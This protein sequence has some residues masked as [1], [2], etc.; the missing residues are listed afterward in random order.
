MS[1]R[2]VEKAGMLHIR[3]RLSNKKGVGVSMV[4]VRLVDFICNEYVV[5]YAKYTE[6]MNLFE[7]VCF[8]LHIYFSIYYC[9]SNGLHAQPGSSCG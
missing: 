7:V 2:I 8:I 3:G 6:I 9:K 5:I 1:K 4:C